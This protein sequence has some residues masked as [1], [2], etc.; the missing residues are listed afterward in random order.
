MA[1]AVLALRFWLASSTVYVHAVD[2][3]STTVGYDDDYSSEVLYVVVPSAWL[4]SCAVDGA[5]V[6]GFQCVGPAYGEIH[7]PIEPDANDDDGPIDPL[8]CIAPYDD[9]TP[10]QFARRCPPEDR[11]PWCPAY[12]PYSDP[13]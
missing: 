9:E 1:I 13:R 10:A 5:T 12:G 11:D 3:G 6:S 2:N 4:P 8:E 7:N